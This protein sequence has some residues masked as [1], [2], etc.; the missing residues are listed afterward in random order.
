MNFKSIIGLPILCFMLGHS[1]SSQT[2]EGKVIA[3]NGAEPLVGATVRQL[4]SI[5]GT[6]TDVAGNFTLTVDRLPVDLVISF[7]SFQPDTITVTNNSFLNL[8][9]KE[10]VEIIGEV[11]IQSNSTFF[12]PLQPILSEVLTE[13]ELE[14]AAC[15]NLSESFE[16]N[17]SIDVSFTDAVSGG[18]IIK[19]LGLDGKYVQINRENLPNI[20]GLISRYGLGFIPGTWLQSIDVGKGIGSVVSGYESMTG[21]INLEIKKPISNE[22]IYFNAYANS[23]G[24]TELN[25]NRAFKIGEKWS[26]AFL[27]HADYLSSTIDRNEDGFQDLPKTRQLNFLNRYAYNGDRVISQLG[28]HLMIDEK[29]GGQNGFG[30][31]DDLL[32]ANAYGF[33]ND[34]KR[35]ELFGKIFLTFPDK[36]YKGLGLVYSLV[37]QEV[38]GGF[39]R[40]IY[41]GEEQSIY[42]NFIY[43]NIISTS[44]HQYKLGTSLLV[45]DFDEVYKDSVFQRKEVV[46][47]AFFEYSYLG[48]S[49]LSFVVGGRVDEHNL[50]GTFFSPRLHAKYD[51]HK[52]LTFRAAAG[53]GYRVPNA[54]IESYQALISS[55]ELV[56]EEA[57]LPEVSWNAGGSV[58]FNIKGKDG[59]QVVADYF[60]TTFENQLI[61]DRDRSSNQL[62]I[63]NLEGRSYA[64][65][66]QIEVSKRFS[67]AFNVKGAFKYYDVKRTINGRLRDA[68][69]IS[70]NRLFLNASYATRFEK[71]KIDGTIQ[72]FS[73]KR[74]PDT[75][76]NIEQF[77]RPGFSDPYTLVNFQISRGFRKGSVYVGS[78]NLFDFR[79]DNPIVDAENPFGNNFDSG[80]VW[81]PV[82]GR[83]IYVGFRYKIKA[84]HE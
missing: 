52:D 7:V 81:G 69:F 80:L 64:N 21:Q 53:R 54:I 14:K 60:Y 72:W 3:T 84:K 75:Q 49:D 17:A 78:E 8:S 13:K 66:F 40:N 19:V 44:F 83:V 55:R 67:E 56:V 18:K 71:W 24:R 57:P 59:Y 39:G 34:T 48:A 27:L 37:T 16:T 77:R 6:V 22:A 32:T 73:K 43:S 70:K 58:L 35:A 29:A 63:Y 62:A 50:Y 42:G 65:S 25:F 31:G 45:D 12:D 11:V 47:G 79:Q 23:F 51:F 4:G 5:K 30:F 28:I 38:A 20:R 46:P 26:T 33:R 10:A 68:P 15:C 1:A 74:I 61:F 2:L 36:P 82:A 9:L 76:D 41:R